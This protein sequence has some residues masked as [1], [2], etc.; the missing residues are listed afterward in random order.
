M[1]AAEREF[2]LFIVNQQKI[3]AAPSAIIGSIVLW[4]L[5]T[6][7]AL[8]L[9]NLSPIAA[10][11]AGFMAMLLHWVFEITHQLGHARAAQQTGHPMLGVR[12]YFLLGAS[13]YPADEGD[14]PAS[15]H[16][17]RALGGPIISTLVLAIATVFLLLS[18]SSVGD[19][20]RMLALFA[21]L[22]NLL[23]FTIGAVI[24]FPFPNLLENDGITLR[25]W[26]GKK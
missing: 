24:P 19:F 23:I 12:L 14:L 5:L 18:W 22:D 26:W 25:R 10:I 9:T 11:L 2:Q 16:I 15:V 17:R 3:S 7:V 8:A 4:I 21:F 13:L 20:L 1:N 6:V